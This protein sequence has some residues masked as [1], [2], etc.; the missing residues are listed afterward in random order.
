ME[1]SFIAVVFGFLLSLPLPILL[2]LAAFRIVDNGAVIL[3]LF[4]LFTVISFGIC[5]MIFRTY[6]KSS[7]EKYF[8][9]SGMLIDVLVFLF[10]ILYLFIMA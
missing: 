9:L 3:M 10:S 4:V 7:F 6:A 2:L 8:A 5:S 1:K